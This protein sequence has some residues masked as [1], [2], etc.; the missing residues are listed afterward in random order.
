MT[1]PTPAPLPVSADAFQDPATAV[2]FALDCLQDFEIGPFLMD[3]REGHG[4]ESWLQHVISIREEVA[5][6]YVHRE[7]GPFD[8]AGVSPAIGRFLE[9]TRLIKSQARDMPLGIS[10][11]FL[12][13]AICGF[14]SRSPDNAMTLEEL[15]DRVD[16]SPTTISQ[17]LR[18]LGSGY[19]EGTPGLGL[20]ETARHPDNGRK[21]VFFLTGKGR[22]LVARLDRVLAGAG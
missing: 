11:A 14:D 22:D 2:S 20:V 3:W 21:K 17:H 19:R 16:V 13:A 6:C 1:T 4:L 5:Q 8:G 9:A 18:Y 15:A 12:A 7:R 10:I